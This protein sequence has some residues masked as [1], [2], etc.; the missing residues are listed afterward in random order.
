MALN[1]SYELVAVPGFKEMQHYADELL[2]ENGLG[3]YTVDVRRATTEE[4][5]YQFEDGGNIAVEFDADNRTMI[6]IIGKSCFDPI[7]GLIEEP[8]SFAVIQVVDTLNDL[9]GYYA[10]TGEKMGETMEI[11][12]GILPL[13][14]AMNNTGWIKTASCCE[15]YPGCESHEWPYIAFFCKASKLSELCKTLNQLEVDDKEGFTYFDLS[16]VHNDYIANNQS[17]AKRGW[18]ALDLQIYMKPL[19]AKIKTFNLLKS[20]FL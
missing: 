11:D 9:I 18:I 10:E 20:S 4:E 7:I 6:M 17:E 2:E 5:L 15:G 19:T 3:E 8:R 12:K 14:N 1:L 13:I 16:V